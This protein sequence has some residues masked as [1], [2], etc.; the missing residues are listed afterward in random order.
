MTDKTGAPSD[1]AEDWNSID[2]K[3]VESQVR[4]LQERIA[5]ATK[6]G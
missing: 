4:R 6:E 5:K 1:H 2:W 3:Q